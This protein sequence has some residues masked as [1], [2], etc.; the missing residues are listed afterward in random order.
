MLKNDAPLGLK[1]ATNYVVSLAKIL[2]AMPVFNEDLAYEEM[3]RAGIPFAHADRTYFFT[4]IAWGRF[5]L[6][7][8]EGLEG[9]GISLSDEYFCCDAQGN[10]IESGKLANDPSFTTA[11]QILR[12]YIAHKPCL[13]FA[14]CSAEVHVANSA[15]NSGAKLEDVGV[16]P[17]CLF[18]EAAT[19][20]GLKRVNEI[21]AQY[22]R[23]RRPNKPTQPEANTAQNTK[24][25][26]QFW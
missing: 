22:L 5:L 7:P 15:L 26:W 16:G 2:A 13:D 17:S 9:T 6:E 14:M 23:D 8:S 18:T 11:R 3:E 10:I 25:W 4:Q 21:I 12:G 24:P 19:D 20:E 1:D